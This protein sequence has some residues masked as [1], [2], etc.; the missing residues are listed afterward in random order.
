MTKIA[1]FIE[2]SLTFSKPRLDSVN[3]III[4]LFLIR[5]KIIILNS[6]M[7]LLLEK[8]TIA[9]AFLC[10]KTYFADCIL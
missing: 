4:F 1:W 8:I 5:K 2:K 7:L 9:K 6:G 3:Q 10:K